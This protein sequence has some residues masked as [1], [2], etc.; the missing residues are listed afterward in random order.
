MFFR[1]CLSITLF[2]GCVSFFLFPHIS[3]ADYTGEMETKKTLFGNAAQRMTKAVGH[4]NH[5]KGAMESLLGEWNDNIDEIES[6]ANVTLKIF[7]GGIISAAVAAS[8]GGSLAPA[9]YAGVLTGLSGSKTLKDI[10]DL[11][12][13]LLAISTTRSIL[14]T[15]LSNV[16]AYYS[17]GKVLVEGESGDD[18]YQDTEGGYTARYSDYL[19][20]CRDHAPWHIPE[21]GVSTKM[22]YDAVYRRLTTNVN[23]DKD[24]FHE[25]GSRSRFNHAWSI[26]STYKHWDGPYT[27]GLYD[28]NTEAL[29]STY[30]CSGGCG[31]SFDTPLGDPSHQTTCHESHIYSQS[32]RKV[33]LGNSYSY[34]I[35]NTDDH[36]CP[37]KT[38]HLQLC[39]GTCNKKNGYLAVSA[40][41]SGYVYPHLVG[42]KKKERRTIGNLFIFNECDGTYY[43][44]AGVSTCTNAEN[45]VEDDEDT[46]EVVDN[47]PNCDYCTGS[48]SACTQ[49]ST[50][51]YH[52]CGVHETSVSGDHSMQASCLETNGWGHTCTVSAFYACQTHTCVFP[53]FSCGRAACTEQVADSEEH[54]RT[55]INGHKYW[56][57]SEKKTKDHKTRTCVRTK[58]VW[59]INPDTGQ[60]EVVKGVCGE[61]WARCDTRCRDALG[62]T[63]D[64]RGN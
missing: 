3:Y 26:P 46:S 51:S 56:S 39:P 47:S 4:Y 16:K 62:N 64:H 7:V 57:C 43:S 50:P 6:G 45:H 59:G 1:K 55:C 17:G 60:P 48:C 61:Q 52:A 2:F 29:P 36:T 42:C 14:D 31:D 23:G 19:E 10:Y 54:R 5:I 18:E 22:D 32:G 35:C 20:E 44:C 28:W 24:Y 34:W 58:W 33:D 9:A 11:S 41:V 15:A 12:E 40:G 21:Q 37:M 53:T 13:Y 38:Y 49:P 27:S 63:R 8:S 30:R 25:D